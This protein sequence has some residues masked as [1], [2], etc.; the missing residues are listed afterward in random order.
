MPSSHRPSASPFFYLLLE[1]DDLSELGAPPFRRWSLRPDRSVKH[2][3]TRADRS[4]RWFV[5][6]RACVGTDPC[7]RRLDRHLGRLQQL[8]TRRRRGQHGDP[9]WDDHAHPPDRRQRPSISRCRSCG[10]SD[11]PSRAAYDPDH[12]D[13]TL[14][15]N[16]GG[17]VRFVAR[18]LP[19]VQAASGHRIAFVSSVAGDRGRKTNF[20]YGHENSAL[21]W[22]W[23]AYEHPLRNRRNTS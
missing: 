22:Q 18:L 15:A 6:D 16:Y 5:R 7:K 4:S 1:L 11:E 3:E 19:H 13:R 8:G 2:G 10:P 17:V 12:A 9:A 20:V 23:Q 14:G 21:L